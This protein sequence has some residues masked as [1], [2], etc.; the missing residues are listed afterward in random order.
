MVPFHKLQNAPFAV[1]THSY[2]LW[3]MTTLKDFWAVKVMFPNQLASNH[4]R[5]IIKTL[6]VSEPVKT[7]E[8]FELHS[9]YCLFLPLPTGATCVLKKKFSASQF[10]NDCKKYNVTVFQYIGELCRYLCKQPQVR[11][12]QSRRCWGFQMENV[13][14]EQGRRQIWFLC[15][16]STGL[17]NIIY[18][19][20]RGAYSVQDEIN[21][22]VPENK[23]QI[24]Q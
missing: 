3:L 10:W 21:T 2:S 19:R 6:E 11:R 22:K 1:R 17:Q 5:W 14:G 7:T 12:N 18:Q 13:L 20:P 16:H 23:R 4:W 8:S 24:T 9:S 15:F